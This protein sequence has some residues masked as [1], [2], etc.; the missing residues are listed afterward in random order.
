ML[1]RRWR[2]LRRLRR[3]ARALPAPGAAADLEPQHQGAALVRNVDGAVWPQAHAPWPLQQLGPGDHLA[4]V[5]RARVRREAEHPRVGAVGDQE[6]AVLR[7]D[8]DAGWHVELPR[9]PAALALGAPRRG[10]RERLPGLEALHPVV[11][12]VRHE[13]R[14]V[15]RHGGAAR[16]REL[17]GLAAAGVGA[18]REQDGRL[19]LRGGVP[20]GRRHLVP[21][22]PV[23]PGVAHHRGAVR[24]E[25]EAARVLDGLRVEPRL[26]LVRRAGRRH[27]L[28]RAARAPEALDAAHLGVQHVDAPL[29][30]LAGADGAL[31]PA[32]LA[33]RGPHRPGLVH[34]LGGVHVLQHLALLPRDD[35]AAP[36]PRL[37]AEA[38]D[39]VV[40]EVR[41]EQRAILAEVQAPRL[42]QHTDL[43]RVDAA[44]LLA[45]PV[46]GGHHCAGGCHCSWRGQPRSGP[47]RSS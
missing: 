45:G 8:A 38:Y 42:P 32:P 27:R 35:L 14:A 20:P 36:V 5:A 25:Q 7:V 47:D 1:L 41:H 46:L 28:G 6:A 22:D 3:W 4:G 31:Q 43:L 30:V 34:I 39:G 24:A 9:A 2:R 12:R 16:E 18:A 19:R 44:A 17:V 10:R 15:R 33:L 37:G 21:E 23:A 13:E 40:A 29:A 11:V 26:R